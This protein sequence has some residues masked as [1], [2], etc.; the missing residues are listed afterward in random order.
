[1]D[2]DPIGEIA[3]RLAWILL[4]AAAMEAGDDVLTGF[5]RRFPGTLRFA[6]IVGGAFLI[7]TG[8]FQAVLAMVFLAYLVYSG[9]GVAS[10]IL[11]I[12]LAF[13]VGITVWGLGMMRR[14]WASRRSVD[15]RA[16]WSNPDPNVPKA[17]DD[18][19]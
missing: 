16:P 5:G 6:R 3:R 10:L 14:G 2:S 9:E 19:H 12:P 4:G 13:G 17:A 11:L 1:M 7:L 18:L 8:L 15:A